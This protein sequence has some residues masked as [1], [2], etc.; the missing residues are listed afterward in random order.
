MLTAL[1]TSKLSDLI[2]RCCFT[3]I[4]GRVTPQLRIVF[5]P[6]GLNNGSDSTELAEVLAVY[7]L[8]AA[9]PVTDLVH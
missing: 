8:G 5:V 7:C 9:I 3:P 2:C 4:G 6:E 1:T